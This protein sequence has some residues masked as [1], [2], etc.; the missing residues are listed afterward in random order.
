M[1]LQ[2]VKQEG[3]PVPFGFRSSTSILWTT[4][5]DLGEAIE[6]KGKKA[7]GLKKPMWLFLQ[8]GSQFCGVHVIMGSM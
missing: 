8:I 6:T 4:V 3:L 5:D 1:I 2:G 7:A